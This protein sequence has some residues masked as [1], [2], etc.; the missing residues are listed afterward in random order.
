MLRVSLCLVLAASG[1]CRRSGVS[2][3]E[4]RAVRPPLVVPVSR[5]CL[6]QPPPAAPSEL[7]TLPVCA[8]GERAGDGACPAM[9]PE[10]ADALE[11]WAAEQSSYAETAWALCGAG[12]AATTGATP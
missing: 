6:S 3:I 7:D 4:P 10:Q 11:R 5:P 1:C 2:A 9:T 8:T 12:T